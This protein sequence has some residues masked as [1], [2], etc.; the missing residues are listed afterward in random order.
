MIRE[1]IVQLSSPAQKVKIPK[2]GK[3][4]QLIERKKRR[5][6]IPD[7]PV[8]LIEAWEPAWRLGAEVLYHMDDPYR[9]ESACYSIEKILFS[10][11]EGWRG[12]YHRA[13][14]SKGQECCAV[15]CCAIIQL[16]LFSSNDS[17]VYVQLFT[18]RNQHQP[19][20]TFPCPHSV[21]Y[22]PK[23]DTPKPFHPINSSLRNSTSSA[24][25]P[26]H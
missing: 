12:T 16:A 24:P 4:N 15:L 13:P 6:L 20:V 19:T 18:S 2:H 10:V 8:A 17:G 9:I 11:A 26:A 3:L 14:F 25:F 23:R 21:A 5:I 7:H 1:T 22:K